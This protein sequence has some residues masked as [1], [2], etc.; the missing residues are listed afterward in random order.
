MD[1]NPYARF[2][3]LSRGTASDENPAGDSAHAGL[4][5]SPVRMRLG[6]VVT[7]APLTVRVAGIV[8]PTSALRINER[9]VKGAEWEVDIAAL[10]GD[11]SEL[12]GPIAGP[13]ITPTGE[14]ALVK[15][16]DGTLHSGGVALSQA[17]VT[18]L[19]ID[20]APGDTVLLLTDDDQI[21]YIVMKVV[22]A[23]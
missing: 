17:T 12:T 1:G 14:G 22:S 21:F 9:L 4:G 15:L 7:A 10:G 13:V 18:Q 5:A 19:A 6:E 23:V 11:F 3:A 8:Q 2:V 20:L 16:T